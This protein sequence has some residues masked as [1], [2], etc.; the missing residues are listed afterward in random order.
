MKKYFKMALLSLVVF[1]SMFTLIGLLF[2][3]NIRSVNAVVIHKKKEMILKEL[4]STS[5]WVKWY[6][7][8]QPLMDG[9]IDHAEKDSTVFLNDKKEML[10]YN[11]KASADTLS[12]FIRYSN[13]TITEHS[14]VVL[15]VSGDSNQVQ[16]IWNEKEKLK[17][18]PWDRFRG[19]VL[20]KVKGEYLDTVLNRFRQYMVTVSSN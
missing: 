11:K 16:V 14:I 17:W 9:H 10:L 2:P 18:Y 15:D 4:K 19:L 8:F 20:E 5:N 13:G 3:S 6:P 1:F 7:F 12:F